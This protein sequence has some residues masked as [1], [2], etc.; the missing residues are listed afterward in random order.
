MIMNRTHKTG[1][2]GE[3]IRRHRRWGMASLPETLYY[4][5][6]VE[7]LDCEARSIPVSFPAQGELSASHAGPPARTSAQVHVLH[8]RLPAPPVL[9]SRAS[10]LSRGH[11]PR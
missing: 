3:K 10:T 6:P 5:I 8:F 9:S 11:K 1:Q 7:I 4:R 2:S